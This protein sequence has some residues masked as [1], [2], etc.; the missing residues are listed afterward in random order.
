MRY[1]IELQYNGAA[2]FG[3]Q[4]QTDMPSVQQ[5]LEQGLSM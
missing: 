5:T 3:W 4:R 2:Y 1:F